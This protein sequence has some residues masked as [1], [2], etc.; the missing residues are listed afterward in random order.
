[1][2]NEAASVAAEEAPPTAND[3]GL[4]DP[5]QLSKS[6]PA[7]KAMKE[8]AK[9]QTPVSSMDGTKGKSPWG[10]S[11]FTTTE[12]SRWTRNKPHQSKNITL[13]LAA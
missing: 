12:S 2:A 3:S 7:Q 9:P 5:Q 13:H 1:M 10:L 8:P 6:D 4:P 11:I